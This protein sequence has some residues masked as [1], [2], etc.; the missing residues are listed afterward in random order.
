MIY[1][2]HGQ[3]GCSKRPCFTPPVKGERDNSGVPGSR[4]AFWDCRDDAAVA[5]S[6]GRAETLTRCSH[7]P[8]PFLFVS[9]HDSPFFTDPRRNDSP[10][11]PFSNTQ[12]LVK[13]THS[14][15]G[16]RSIFS[17]PF[18]S[19]LMWQRLFICCC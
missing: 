7:V 6:N 19:N 10:G 8:F 1:V 14:G 4:V 18:E 11:R 9:E 17:A 5:A 13:T 15:L 2:K 3:S 12:R 16:V